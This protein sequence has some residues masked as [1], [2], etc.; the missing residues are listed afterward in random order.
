MFSNKKRASTPVS[1]QTPR[2]HARTNLAPAK[3][4]RH[5]GQLWSNLVRTNSGH[6]MAGLRVGRRRGSTNAPWS[7]FR[8]FSEHGLTLDFFMIELGFVYKHPPFGAGVCLPHPLAHQRFGHARRLHAHTI[9]RGQVWS[10]SLGA[11]TPKMFGYLRF[12]AY[13]VCNMFVWMFLRVFWAGGLAT[14]RAGPGGVG[15]GGVGRGQVGSGVR[16]RVGRAGWVGRRRDVGCGSSCPRTHTSNFWHA[17]RLRAHTHTR[18]VG[19]CGLGALAHARPK[20]WGSSSSLPTLFVT[21]SYGDVFASVLGG[22]ASHGSGGAGWGWEGRGRKGSGGFG[23]ARS[24]GL[25]G[26]GR[27]GSGVA[28]RR[29]G[30]ARAGSLGPGRHW[31]SRLVGLSH[32]TWYVRQ[33]VFLPD[34]Y[35]AARTREHTLEST[36]QAFG[37]VC[38]SLF[39]FDFCLPRFDTF[40]PQ[41]D[42]F[43]ENGA[44]RSYV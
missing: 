25:G 1:V 16:D 6:I 13:I 9:T 32:C 27:A 38:A 35:S 14:G 42:F 23:R 12:K 11:G 18:H 39:G 26:P 24:R 17:R 8:V 41:R 44:A 22:R 36:H 7:I 43:S 5:C 10:G 2:A 19:R 40:E 30:L 3:S 20:C 29:V 33:V 37:Q 34:M 28:G 21:C 31:T 15:W 4:S